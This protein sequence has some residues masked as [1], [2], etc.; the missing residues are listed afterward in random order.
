MKPVEIRHRPGKHYKGRLSRYIQTR[1]R[2]LS[3]RRSWL[4]VAL[5]CKVAART[6]LAFQS[7]F[8]FSPF[9]HTRWKVHEKTRQKHVRSTKWA[10]AGLRH[11]AR[12]TRSPQCSATVSATLDALQRAEANLRVE[13]LLAA[14]AV[15]RASFQDNFLE[16]RWD[17]EF[18]LATRRISERLLP[19]TSTWRSSPLNSRMTASFD[20]A[21]P[22]AAL[23]SS[24][25]TAPTISGSF[26]KA[27][28][29]NCTTYHF[30]WMALSAR[31]RLRRRA[32][33][34][35]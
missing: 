33:G 10:A 26:C 20:G 3:R 15:R 32:S 17:V 12:E 14:R 30:F 16:A 28:A 27:S 2:C 34:A 11:F 25:A 1:R 13:D 19:T 18:A 29:V 21:L 22:S 8:P 4:V 23:G 6:K 5:I 35:P 24:S 7:A 31:R 9:Q